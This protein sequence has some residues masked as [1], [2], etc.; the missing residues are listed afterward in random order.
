MKRLVVLLAAVA[1]LAIGTVVVAANNGPAEIKLAN[2]MG[3]ITFNH[4]AHQGKVA[5]CKTCHHK[6][7]EA[8]KCTG[9][10]G[11]KPEAPAAKDAFHK[12]CKGCHQ[13]KGGPTGCKDC[14]K[15]AKS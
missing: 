11:V 15:G 5:D 9:C 12:Q 2:K 13:E 3:E 1:F 10:H 4:A 7:V 14:H 8:G 6:G